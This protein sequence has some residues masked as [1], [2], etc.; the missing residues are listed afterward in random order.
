MNPFVKLC[1]SVYRRLARAFPHEFWM[2]YGE[3]LRSS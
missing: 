3:D 1:L 2:I